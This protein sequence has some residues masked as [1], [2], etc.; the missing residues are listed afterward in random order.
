MSAV[1]FQA[2]GLLLSYPDENLIDRL[3]M[4]EQA[5]AEAGAAADFAPTLAHLRSMP[6]ME[7]QSWHVQ[8][9][10]LSRRHALHLTYWTDGDT[11]RRGEVLAAIKQTYR[12]SGLLVDLDGELPDYLPMVLEF[13]ATGDRQLGLGILN[14]YRASL[15]LLR[16]GLADDDLPQAGVV[17]A[18]CTALGGQSPR[19]REQV[20]QLQAGPPN[21]TVGLD[22]V[23]LPYPTL[24]GT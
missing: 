16:I 18:I 14:R 4:I 12:E 3:P 6:L 2:A 15:E 13:T 10:D 5:V 20:R 21:E 17:A 1:V 19:T 9:F 23:L 8:E 11:R 7:L 22:P 24:Q